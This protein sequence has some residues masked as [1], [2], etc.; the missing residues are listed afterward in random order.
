MFSS[1][2]RTKLDRLRLG[3][4][5][6]DATK[7]IKNDSIAE[8]DIVGSG[9]TF[10]VK[11]NKTVLADGSTEGILTV[12]TD[13]GSATTV[14]VFSSA[15]RT[16]LDRLR[17]G[18]NPANASESILNS[19]IVA[20]DIEGTGK[21]FPANSV[22]KLGGIEAGAT[23][24]A[25]LGAQG[26]GNIVD[27]DGN[28]LTEDDL[29]TA[30]GTADD[31]ANVS[32]TAASTVKNNAAVGNTSATNLQSTINSLND[33]SS[34][35]AITGERLT[36]GI[37][38]GSLIKTDELALAT[39]GTAATGTSITVNTTT[40]SSDFIADL[41]TG[42][43]MYFGGITFEVDSGTNIYQGSV[44]LDIREG[45][46]STNVFEKY[47]PKMMQAGAVVYDHNNAYTRFER[48]MHMEFMF[49]Y[50]G[51]NTLKAYLTAR[52]SHSSG[53]NC[54]VTLRAAKF[55]AEGVNQFTFTDELSLTAASNN[56]TYEESNAVT[57]AGFSGTQTASISGHSSAEF[58]VNSGSFSSSDKDVVPNDTVTVRILVP[59]T[60][61]TTRSATLNVGGVA[62]TYSIR[63]TGT[64]TPDP[65]DS[66]N[67]FAA[68]TLI[69]LGDLNYK[70]IEE[71]VV[72]DVVM[73]FNQ[74]TLAY[75]PKAVEYVMTPR[76][77][78]I[79][80]FS[81]NET[82]DTLRMTD[83]H[84]IL[85]EDG[86]WYAMDP[87]KAL[88]EHRVE[89]L[90]LEQGTELL[91]YEMQSVTLRN[92]QYIGEQETY[93]LSEIKDNHSFV[94]DGFIAHNVG[95]EIKP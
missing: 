67:C 52:A 6:S 16:K 12:A 88:E 19:A 53:A 69:W 82:D 66:F 55:A 59:Q 39:K 47:F 58:K 80:E 36:G 35:L 83:A 28:A 89:C 78:K 18:Q 87:E 61:A 91:H 40:D 63:T 2:E 76:M 14:N 68:G 85:G 48:A 90:K 7:S 73:S 70:P 74:D 33:P 17:L 31:T 26:D 54:T 34:S 94:A 81:F 50:S 38:D 49:F 62:D 86:E 37:I 84:P 8:A 21:A 41:G 4:D 95:Q 79:Y 23:A 32:G 77:G 3:Q 20:A 46:G 44:H 92:I 30:N 1:A 64:Y 56:T 22:S 29:I 13:G 60:S 27:S 57:I 71:V 15:E 45:S 10:S 25:T 93:N 51:T 72:G 11:P 43:G 65:D 75:E 42:A 9:K 5:P 24:G